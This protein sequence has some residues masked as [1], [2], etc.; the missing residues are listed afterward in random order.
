MGQST[1]VLIFQILWGYPMCNLVLWWLHI[2]IYSQPINVYQPRNQSVK[3]AHP[4]V[5]FGRSLSWWTGSSSTSLCLRDFS[6][7][8]WGTCDA[9]WDLPATL[10]VCSVLQL[11]NCKAAQCMSFVVLK[12]HL[13]CAEMVSL[14]PWKLIITDSQLLTIMVFM[15]DDYSFGLNLW[16]RHHP[17]FSGWRFDGSKWVIGSGSEYMTTIRSKPPVCHAGHWLADTIV[18]KRS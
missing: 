5:A 8:L 2:H 12:H 3:K 9:G 11:F 7:A 10:V 17:V 6:E 1:R 4:V 14:W 18:C 13:K 15:N 16:I